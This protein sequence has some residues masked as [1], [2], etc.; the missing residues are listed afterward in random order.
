MKRLCNLITVLLLLT[1]PALAQTN[2]PEQIV[3]I[4]VGFPAGTAPDVAAR[5]IADKFTVDWGKPVV[6]ENISGA[7]GNIASDRV[8]KAAPDGYTLIMGG[9]SARHGRRVSTTS[10]PSIR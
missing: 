9:N 1:S 4:L 7:S 10:C 2:Y 6:V 5:L 8:A 3:R